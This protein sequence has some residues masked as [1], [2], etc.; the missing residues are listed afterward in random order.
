MFP[1]LEY[2]L[3]YIRKHNETQRRM[4]AYFEKFQLSQVDKKEEVQGDIVYNKNIVREIVKMKIVDDVLT[5]DIVEIFDKNQTV[6]W[7]RRDSILSKMKVLI[8]KKLIK[9]AYSR[10]EAENIANG[11]MREVIEKHKA[12]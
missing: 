11:I 6:D 9:N 7:M 5:D 4:V 2:Q 8:C 3:R 12:R 10:Q 1:E